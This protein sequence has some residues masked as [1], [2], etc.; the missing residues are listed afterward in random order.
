MPCLIGNKFHFSYRRSS[1]TRNQ[2]GCRSKTTMMILM[3]S[4]SE[5]RIRVYAPLE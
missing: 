3:M 5:G 1:Q 2:R 4:E